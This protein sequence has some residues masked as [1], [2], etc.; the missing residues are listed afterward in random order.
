MYKLP[1]DCVRDGLIGRDVSILPVADA[2]V[3]PDT[4]K[5]GHCIIPNEPVHGNK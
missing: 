2:A 5:S 3:A 1:I 4:L